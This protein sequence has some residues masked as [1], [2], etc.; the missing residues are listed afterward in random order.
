MADATFT[1]IDDGRAT[2][3][4]ATREGDRV[5][6]A[7]GALK[8]ALGWELKPEGLCRDDACVPLRDR[9]GVETDGGIDL[10]AVAEV[11]QRPLALDADAG[12]AVLTA[13]PDARRE[14]LRSL[15][16]PDFTLPDLDGTQHSLSHFRGKKILLVVYA[17]W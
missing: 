17:S 9:A 4:P 14:P 8:A 7:P 15:E 10:A 1:V 13:S 2:E 16:A 5:C 3:V 6:L 11:L 12:V